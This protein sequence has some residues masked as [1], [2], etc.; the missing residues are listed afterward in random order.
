MQGTSEMIV[1]AAISLPIHIIILIIVR[2]PLV[3]FFIGTKQ[4]KHWKQSMVQFCSSAISLLLVVV[5]LAIDLFI[6]NMT[7]SVTVACYTSLHVVH[8]SYPHGP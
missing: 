6:T 5:F 1:A 4:E 3:S 8:V 2:Q 7:V